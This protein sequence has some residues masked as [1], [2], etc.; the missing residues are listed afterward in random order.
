MGIFKQVSVFTNQKI[1]QISP[2]FIQQKL[3]L[4]FFVALTSGEPSTEQ[5]FWVNFD[6]SR[7]FQS[8]PMDLWSRYSPFRQT[9][10]TLLCLGR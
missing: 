7:L 5:L 10:T 2:T 4:K 3:D 6:D 8:S 9:E 1:T